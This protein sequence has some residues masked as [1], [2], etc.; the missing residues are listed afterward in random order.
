MEHNIKD[1]TKVVNQLNNFIEVSRN[2]KVD[3][4]SHLV[5]INNKWYKLSNN[6]G[7]T[8]LDLVNSDG[9]YPS[10]PHTS[11]KIEVTPLVLAYRI[12]TYI[13]DDWSAIDWDATDKWLRNILSNYNTRKAINYTIKRAKNDNGWG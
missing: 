13:S 5:E 11:N 7:E 12:A 1:Y 8:N 4:G 10:I 2:N 6:G 9:V 3:D